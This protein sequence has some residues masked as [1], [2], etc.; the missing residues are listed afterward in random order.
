MIRLFVTDIDGCLA[1]PYRPF[2]LEPMS[3]LARL[4]REA[5]L[6][7]SHRLLPAI[8]I[9]SGRSYPY[10]EAMTQLLGLQVPVLFEAG[11]GMFDPRTARSL[12]HPGFDSVTQ[13]ALEQ[14]L[15]FIEALIAGT[16][17]V[18][19]HAKKTQ[20]AVVGTD[21]G[22]LARA[23]REIDQFVRREHPSFRTYDTPISIDVVASHLTKRSGLEWLADE[24]NLDPSEIAYIGD[25]SGDIEALELAGRSYAPANA[26]SEIKSVV[27]VTTQAEYAEGVVS[28]YWDVVRMN[29]AASKRA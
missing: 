9:C 10:V 26:N 1:T 7:G 29:E 12:W 19:D 8:S 4:A 14:I 18:M 13:A 23:T 27:D 11:A 20:A 6:P 17:L 15:V 2:K 22:R 25:T 28:A 3:E 5:A 21:A 16:P 24:V